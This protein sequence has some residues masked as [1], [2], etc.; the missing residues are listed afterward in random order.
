MK[1]VYQLLAISLC[2][3]TPSFSSDL[4]S[5]IANYDDEVFSSHVIYPINK[6]IEDLESNIIIDPKPFTDIAR[7]FEEY[8]EVTEICQDIETAIKSVDNQSSLIKEKITE[9]K[10]LFT[11]R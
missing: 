1:K 4:T 3:A 5:A 6:A 10:K 2:L 8:S 9:L 7:L 11:A